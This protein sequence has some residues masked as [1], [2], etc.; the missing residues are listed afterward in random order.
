VDL[1][2]GRPGCNR[3]TRHGRRGRPRDGRVEGAHQPRRERQQ[4]RQQVEL[5]DVYFEPTFIKAKAGQK[6]K[7]EA[8]NEGSMVHTFTSDK[9]N[10]NKEIQPGKKATFTIT[11]PSSGAAF[12]FHCNFH[13]SQGMAGGVYTKAGATAS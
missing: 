6:I 1:Q 5:D 8:E 4:P 13:V 7:I 2:G 3:R 10:V 9:L 12:E 11:V